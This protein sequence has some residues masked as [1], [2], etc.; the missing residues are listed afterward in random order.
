MPQDDHAN[1]GPAE[2]LKV[3]RLDLL[4][5]GLRN[6]LLNY[7]LFRAR[8][9]EIAGEDPAEVFRILV[10]E[11]KRMTFLPGEGTGGIDDGHFALTQPDDERT[12]NRHTDLHLQTTHTS[13]QLQSRLLA[14]YHAART[15]MEE[16]GVNTLYLALGLLRWTEDEN[17]EKV[18]RAPLILVPV[19]LERSDAR[20]RFHL[21]YTGEEIGDNISLAEKLKT[22]YEFRTFPVLPEPEDLDVAAY[23]QEV[24]RLVRSRKGWEVESSAIALG[25]FSFAKFLM[26][27]DLDP[28]TW[29]EAKGLLDHDILQKLLGDSGFQG[30][31]SKYTEDRLLD[32][33]VRDRNLVQVVDADSSQTIAI[34]DALDGRNMVIQGPPGTGK[35]QTIVNL[36]GA[37]VAEG[38]K[39]LFVSEKMA[40]LDVVKRRLDAARVGAACLELHSN[41]SNK[42]TVIEELKRTVYRDRPTASRSDKDLGLLEAARDKLNE[43]C[44]AVNAGIGDTGETPCSAYGKLLDA[45]ETLRGVE[46]PVLKLESSLWSAADSAKRR[47][48]TA[49][50]QERVARCGVPVRH[51]FWGSN[52]AMLL[53]TDREEIGICIKFAIQQTAA[54][55]DASARLAAVCPADPPVDAAQTSLLAESARFLASAPDLGDINHASVGWLQQEEPIARIITAGKEHRS[56]RRKFEGILQPDAWGRDVLELRRSVADVGSRWWRF[57]S[58]RWWQAKAEVASLCEGASPRG[59]ARMLALLDAIVGVSRSAKV[60]QDAD[61][62]MSPLFRSRWSGIGSDWDLMERQAAWVIDAHRRVQWGKIPEWCVGPALKSIDR[63]QV[64]QLADQATKCLT[65]LQEAMR[66][67]SRRLQYDDSKGTSSLEK[68]GFTELEGQLRLQLA[69]LDQLQ[70]LVGFNQVAAEC[71]KS[72]LDAVAELA[73]EWEDAARHLVPV[74]ERSRLSSILERAFRERPALATFDGTDHAKT[75]DNFRRLDLLQLEYSRSLIAARHGESI[76]GGS[77]SGELG[78]LWRE[79][80][81]KRRHLPIRKLMEMAGHAIQSIKPV[82]MMSPLSIANYLPPGCLSF[83]LVVFDEASQVKP[84]DALG[85]VVRAS[86]IV[87]VGDSKQLPPTTFF[88]SLVNAE[89]SEGQ[90]GPATSDIES[91]LGL[92]CA[93]GAHQRMLRWH[94]RSRHESLITVSNHLFYDD[95][96]VVFPSPTRDRET[97][98]LVYRRVENAW[99]DRSRTRSN[100]EEAKAVAAAVMQHARKQL[101]LP[102]EQRDTLGVAAFSVAQMDAILTQVELLRRNDPSCEEFFGYPPHEPFF[103]K[104]LENVQGDERDVIFISVGYGRTA[105]GF[106]AMSFGPLNR[107]GGERRLN[108]LISRARKRCEVFTSLSAED[109]DLSRTQSTGVASLKTFLQYAQTGQIEVSAPSERPPDSDFEEQVERRLTALGYTVH[110]QVGCA[111]FFLDLAVLDQAHPGKYL[112]GIECDGARYHSARSARDRDRLRQNVLEGLGWQ[113]HRIWSTDW[114]NNPDQELRKLVHAIDVCRTSGPSRQAPLPKPEPPITSGETEADDDRSAVVITPVSSP[115]PAYECATVQLRLGSVEMHQVDRNHLADLLAQVVKVESPVHWKEAARRVMAAAGVQKLG[116]RIE[117]A[118][119]EAARRGTSRRLFARRGEFLW[120]ADMAEP[121]VRDRSNLPA[122]SRRLDLVAPE[123]IQRAI[124]KVIAESY[125]MQPDEVPGAVCRILGFARVTDEMRS[126]VEPHREALVKKGLLM[127]NGRNLTVII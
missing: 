40:A 2:A 11:E 18:C 61:P 23:F 103:I 120:H 72:A 88:D 48:L 107:S 78:V 3:A 100:P 35:S 69:S 118:F 28:G 22:E 45:Q 113:I 111:G 99:Y 41:R 51:P 76:P 81:K 39:V 33:Q 80:E 20:D 14:T 109:I 27:R 79:F 32:E 95:R 121:T 105:D 85:A 38:K 5:L 58:G 12:I 42:K 60:V 10:K 43:Y 17:S 93:R 63:I 106:L 29:I 7:R 66:S 16:Q 59:K 77:G 54:V 112:L 26:Y 47:Q 123:E 92:F 4:D 97:L 21:T 19:G 68:R 117:T 94:Y 91:I 98:G 110:T 65:G 73:H 83:D 37:A 52:L 84:V 104:N 108:V 44:K 70:A 57:L 114:F 30:D 115:A 1:L 67:W 74:F 55:R 96:L 75:V 36:I 6:P 90:E 126:A 9:V 56:L 15:S 86:Q 87:V 13:A 71:R 101:R 64:G 25:F 124:L 122:A 125:G 49:Q 127:Q 82:F 31:A 50:L 24:Q 53:P 102:R 46:I 62:V 89:E 8:G 116:S 34:L 119:D